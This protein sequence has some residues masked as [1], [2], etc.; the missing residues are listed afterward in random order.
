MAAVRVSLRWLGCRKAL[1]AEQKATAADAF[2]ASEQFVTAGKKLLDTKHPAFRNV[3]NVR[4][5]ILA[6]WRGMTLPFPEPGIRLIRRD[7]VELFHSE[8]IDRRA[9]LDA[10]VAALDERFDELK[11]ASRQRL[12]RLFNANDYPSTLRGLFAVEWD[13]PAVEPPDYLAELNPALYDEECRRVAARFDEALALAE[14][15]FTSELAELVTH[16][17]ER[18]AGSTDGKPKVFRDTTITNLVEFFG[19]FRKLNVRSSE[20]LDSLVDQAQQIV[21]GIAPQSL[22]ENSILRQTVATELGALRGTLDQLLV[23]RPRRNILRRPQP[24]RETA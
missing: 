17:S 8:M 9:E 11:S 18:L 12:G 19:R 22:R 23:D 1:S 13:F 15:A 16:L 3:T 10:A 7:Q 14:E 5:R 2:D 4:G 20:Q 21:Q 24:P 6:L